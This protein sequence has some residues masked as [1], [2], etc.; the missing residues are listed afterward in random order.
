M[1]D[2]LT[3]LIL[4]VMAICFCLTLKA[5]TESDIVRQRDSISKLIEKESDLAKLAVLY[6]QL[7]YK[8]LALDDNAKLISTAEKS[9]SYARQKNVDDIAYDDNLLLGRAY[10]QT[11]KPEEA[12]H[13]Y[14]SAQSLVDRKTP[15]GVVTL[16]DIGTEIGMVYFNR[17]HY[18]RAAENFYDALRVYESANIDDKVRQSTNQLAVCAYL[19]QNYHTAVKYYN[20]LLDYYTADGDKD[21]QK[22]VL[23]RLADIYLKQRDYNKA[24]ETNRTLYDMCATDG[25]TPTAL[26]ALN[27]I[28]YC[29][30]AGG[31]SDGALDIFRQIT[32]TDQLAGATDDQLAGT[33]TNIGLCYQNMGKKNECYQ[34]L[35]Q[36]ADI[37]KKNNQDAEFSQVTNI[38]ALVYLKD[39]DLHNA[40]LTCLEA[41]DAAERS[42][43]PQ[44]QE[45]AYQTYNQILQ[46]KGEYDKA[47]DY[48]QKYLAL[49]DSAQ[50]HEI[51]ETRDR[52]DDLHKLEEAEKRF[53]EE[54]V[55]AEISELTNRQLQLLAE[56]QQ[57]KNELL[58]KDL[59]LQEAEQNRLR[60][61][62]A[63]QRQREEAARRDAEIQKLEA[64]RA[65]DEAELAQ[66][67]AE[68]KLRKSEI[69]NL[70]SQRQRQELELKNERDEKRIYHL[71]LALFG[72]VVAVFFAIFIIVRRKN[73]KLNEQKLEIECQNAALTQ[74]NEE[75]S[76]Q[77]ENLQMANQEI[78][79]INEEIGRQ[80]EIIEN[81]NKSI[82][83]SIIYAQRIQQAVCPMP[84]FLRNFG[85]D[86][87]L[88]FRP[89][90]I[91]SG[92]FYWFYQ[93]GSIVFCVA[94]DCT[95]H[96]V[97][98]AFMSMLGNS[99]LT[100]I[101][102]ERKLFDPGAILNQLRDEVKRALHQQDIHSERKDG[103]DLSLVKINTD[104]LVLEFSG[105]NN[106]GYLVRRFAKGDPE[107]Q[108]NMQGRDFVY[109]TPEHL[110][111]LITLPAEKMPIGV[112]IRDNEQFTTKTMQL[113]KGDSIYLTSDG[114]IDQFGGRHGRKF[115]SVNFT[116]M[117]VK[118]NS[119]PMEQQRDT[120]IKTHED[121]I[122]DSFVQI[123]DIIVFGLR[124]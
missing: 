58:A 21:A 102:N 54:I 56:A 71:I 63:L 90:E 119:L 95:G 25:D 118:M 100:K 52:A 78:M 110:L 87:F 112:Y 14:L 79:T 6:N 30:V 113:Q 75:I 60:Q 92:D 68:E 42:G 85:L 9:L 106:N 122:G 22:N 37:R 107:A 105:A 33:Y 16:A 64:Q 74:K 93:E 13:C 76:L 111:R 109:E 44:L 3:K 120:V 53:S 96:G 88:F 15:E 47:L 48:Y 7:A 19:T 73:K 5:Q 84:E 72:V 91:V 61:Q 83:D 65:Q 36:A 116:Q 46:A 103:M 86:Y 12:L 34:Y 2:K 17:G 1:T 32:A 123:D 45:D 94:A 66:K 70:E 81:K 89:K 77:K 99:L 24:L 124:I 80:K 104:N 20:Q 51:L 8:H 11:D 38:M 43:N 26:N 98:G 4:T 29:Q 18:N 35:G 40:E 31:S 50:L 97:P 57:R 41:I 101:I 69:E 28:A 108:A 49:R 55:D 27:N 117:V 121:W 10:S 39:K 114:Y 82:T 23:R 59:E 115:L 62:L 67:E